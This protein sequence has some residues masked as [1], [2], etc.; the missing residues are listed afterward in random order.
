MILDS[1]SDV[2][3]LPARFQADSLSGFTPGTL[4]NCQRG[5]LQTSGVKKAV[6]V[7]TTLDGEKVLLQH[8]FIVGNV[9]FCL[10][11]LGQL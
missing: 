8:D 2:S 7:A 1:G 5:S 9:T 3:L 10:V 4:Q 11:S 6:L